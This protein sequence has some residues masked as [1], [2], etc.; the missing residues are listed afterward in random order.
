MY[1]F[2]GTAAHVAPIQDPYR[3][4]LKKENLATREPRRVASA[5]TCPANGN[6]QQREEGGW[7]A[8]MGTASVHKSCEL[9]QGVRR[10]QGLRHR[11]ARQGEWR[12]RPR[13]QGRKD[14]DVA[15]VKATAQ[16]ERPPK[17]RHFAGE[18]KDSLSVS[19]GWHHSRPSMSIVP[20]NCSLSL[21]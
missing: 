11:G 9:A 14:L 20:S 16:V 1:L 19:P 15:V 7:P 4:F 17:E 5:M 2:A 12:Q 21:Q 6:G 10:H 8:L 18:I 13:A 3:I